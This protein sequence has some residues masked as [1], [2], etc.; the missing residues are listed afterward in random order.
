MSHSEP[1]QLLG[2]KVL[3]SILPHHIL[4]GEV[5][6]FLTFLGMRKHKPDEVIHKK[7]FHQERIF[8]PI[9]FIDLI[10]L[11]IKSLRLVSSREHFKMLRHHSKDSAKNAKTTGYCN[12]YSRNF[13]KLLGQICK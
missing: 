3:L 11:P 6:T 13:I 8:T 12:S 2:Y 1:E 4:L 10:L 7:K 5:N 9:G